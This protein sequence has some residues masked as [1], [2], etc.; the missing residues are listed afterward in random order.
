MQHRGIRLATNTLFPDSSWLS[1]RRP[2]PR[3]WCRKRRCSRS[4]HSIRSRPVTSDLDDTPDLYIYARSGQA[5]FP[6]QGPDPA[7]TLLDKLGTERIVKAINSPV[8]LCRITIMG[9]P[10]GGC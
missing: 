2:M 1:G 3:T 6:T 4:E 8:S 5:G 10:R 7:A 9:T